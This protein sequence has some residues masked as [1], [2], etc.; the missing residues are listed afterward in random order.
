MAPFQQTMKFHRSVPLGGAVFLFLGAVVPAGF[1]QM[2]ISRDWAKDP[3]VVQID[4]KENIFAVGDVHG[5]C[6]RLVKL[7][8]GAKVVESVAGASANAHW[9]AGKATLVFTGDLIDKGPKMLAVIALVRSLAG[10]AVQAGGRV[11]ALMGNHEN[12]FLRTP[13]SEKVKDFAAQLRAAG[14]D[15]KAVA[16]CGGDAG[17]FLCA[18]PFAARVN[19]WFFSHAGNS[20]GRTIGELMSDLQSGVDKEGFGTSELAGENSLITA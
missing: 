11:V 13:D 7:L 14:L 4:T 16:A 1:S 8:A 19:D 17:A 9:I 2:K 20:G 15:P 6:D 18:M 3:A 5:D 12:D 10:E